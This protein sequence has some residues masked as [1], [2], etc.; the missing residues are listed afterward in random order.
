MKDQEK[1]F[2]YLIGSNRTGIPFANGLVTV[3]G[4]PE[5]NEGGGNCEDW[6]VSGANR[7]DRKFL[8]CTRD[9]K[10]ASGGA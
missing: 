10:R 4:P 1:R 2:D 7:I 9:C 6:P 3:T 5:P 8:L